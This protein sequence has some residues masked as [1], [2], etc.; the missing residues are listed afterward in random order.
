PEEL[1]AGDEP[2]E[3]DEPPEGDEPPEDDEPEEL[4]EDDEGLD[5]EDVVPV[6]ALPDDPRRAFVAGC[7]SA[8]E[9]GGGA[10]FNESLNSSPRRCLTSAVS[11]CTGRG[12]A[13]P[14]MRIA[15]DAVTSTPAPKGWRVRPSIWRTSI[16]PLSTVIV[17]V[18]P[19]A[20]SPTCDVAC[21]TSVMT[22]VPRMPATAFGVRISIC[23]PA[24][25]RSFTTARAILPPDTSMVAVCGDSLMVNAE[26]SRTV[27]TALPPSKMRTS[28]FSPVT[29]RSATNTSSRGLSCTPCGVAT[30]VSVAEPCNVATTPTR[31]S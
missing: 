27:T 15:C 16:A 17:V 18:K 2:P 24:F 19:L 3:V 8:L 12:A 13:A 14:V 31:A 23:S 11:G 6:D 9:G 26:R 22:T 29:M 4:P 1:P 25:I 5:V 10:S 7:S 21:D 28:A 20:D 30:R